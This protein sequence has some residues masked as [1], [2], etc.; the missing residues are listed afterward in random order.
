VNFPSASGVT[1][2]EGKFTLGTN[3]AGDGAP[4]GMCKV[5]VVFEPPTNDT[6]D[7]LPIDNPN[8]L[9]KPKVA[10]PAKYSSAATSGLT[11]EVPADGLTDLKIDL[12]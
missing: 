5:A 10:I 7:G 4:P 6:A 8:L 9:P 2:A 11:Q 12:Q 1:D 3:A